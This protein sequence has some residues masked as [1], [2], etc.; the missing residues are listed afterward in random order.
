LSLLI[1]F[2]KRMKDACAFDQQIRKGK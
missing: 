2:G 1:P